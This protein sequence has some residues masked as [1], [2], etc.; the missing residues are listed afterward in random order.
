MSAEQSR[1]FIE[2]TVKM[3]DSGTMNGLMIISV[4]QYIKLAEITDAA[5]IARLRSYGSTHVVQCADGVSELIEVL[6]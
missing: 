2:A 1:D 5:E 3:G 6:E 4:D